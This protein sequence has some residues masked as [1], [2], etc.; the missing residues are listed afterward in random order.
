MV[1]KHT[2]K[3]HTISF[4]YAFSGL[5]HT[6]KT[7]PNL[8]IH[9]TIA[10]LVTISG[11][12]LKI[13]SLEWVIIVFTFLWVIVSEMINTSIESVVDLIT[14]TKHQEAKIAKDVA[15][16]M[17][18]VGAIGSVIVGLIIFLPKILLIAN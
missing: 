13:S 1:N 2:L 4:R 15:A 3:R 12:L 17:V 5:W 18:L 9:L 11:Y 6:I 14:T 7:Q 16:G 10:T 8:R